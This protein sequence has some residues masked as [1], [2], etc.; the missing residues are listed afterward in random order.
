MTYRS[1]GTRSIQFYAN[2][3]KANTENVGRV[4]ARHKSELCLSKTSKTNCDV[5]YLKWYPQV[6]E[7][8]TRFCV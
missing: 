5:M 8:N 6:S 3:L 7:K 2:F 1:R 4:F